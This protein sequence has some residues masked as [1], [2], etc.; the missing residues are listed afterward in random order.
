[1]GLIALDFDTSDLHTD[2]G[3]N[4]IQIPESRVQLSDEQLTHLLTP[5]LNQKIMEW[6]CIFNQ[7]TWCIKC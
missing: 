5:Y 1:M 2:D 3:S 7:E 4:Q 6:N